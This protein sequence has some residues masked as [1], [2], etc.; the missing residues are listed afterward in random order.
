MDA[1]VDSR[2]VA[3]TDVRSITL[4]SVSAGFGAR[5]GILHA[6]QDRAHDRRRNDADRAD[7]VNATGMKA[8]AA[9]ICDQIVIL[10]PFDGATAETP[11]FEDISV[12]DRDGDEEAHCGIRE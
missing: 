3:G 1:G 6:G 11:G 5:G 4:P 7:D 2:E 9:E 10:L 8:R 12:L